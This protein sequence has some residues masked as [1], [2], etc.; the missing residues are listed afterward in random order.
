MPYEKAYHTIAYRR[1][2]GRLSGLGEIKPMN[3]LVTGS[4]GLVGSALVRRLTAVGHQVTRLVRTEP[5]R[6]AGEVAWD[7]MAN[8]IATPAL[9]GLDAVVHLA[10]E[11]IAT[12]RWTA[13]KKARIR[14]SRVKGT[15]LLCDALAQLVEAPKVLVNASAIG[16][17][18]DRGDQVMREESRPGN[19]FLA[20]VCRDWEAATAPAEERGIRVV[21]LRFGVILSTDGGALAK[22]L[23]PFK[24]GAGGVMGSGQQYMSWITLDDVVGII[25]HAMQTESLCGPVNAVAPHPVQNHAFTKALGHVL[26]RPT[27]VP[28]PSPAVRILFGEMG[29]ALLLS[30]TR[31]SSARLEASGYAFRHP[32]LEGA[33]RSLLRKG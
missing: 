28:M 30:S 32:D 15:R 3:V 27:M 16:Y 18:G 17:Y 10:G 33:L 23:T 7:P 14:D 1:K 5:Q 25:E 6:G 24:L 20:D 8:R 19:D 26:R 9:E 13:A 12:G 2:K 29:D 11:N 21:K 4:S 22:M 31:V